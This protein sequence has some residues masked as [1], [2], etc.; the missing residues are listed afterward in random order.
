MNASMPTAE[1]LFVLSLGVV[2]CVG[3]PPKSAPAQAG[4]ASLAK[5]L[6]RADE[7]YR[8]DKLPD[9]AMLYRQALTTAAGADRHRCFDQLLA[10]YVRVG[11]QDQAIQTGKQYDAWLRK[12]GDGVRARALA[13]DLGRW[14]LAL[15]HYADAE[16][17]L[18]Q[19]LAD[20]KGAALPPA[21]QITALTYLALAAE[22]QGAAS[23]AAQAWR[24]VETFARTQLGD[25]GQQLTL[26]LRIECTRR[27]A[28]SYRFQG[29]PAEAIKWLEPVVS[30][31]GRLQKPDPAG[32]RD[33]LRQ[34]AAHLTAAKRHADA[35]KYLKEALEL[36]RKYA[37]DDPLTRADLS[38]ELADVLER[39]DRLPEATLLRQQ[40][41]QDYGSVLGDQRHPRPKLAGALAAFWK[42]Q[43]LHQRAGQ[44]NRALQLLQDSAGQWGGGLIEPRLHAEQGRLQVLLARYAPSRE[45]LDGVVVELE[46]QVPLN[47]IDLPP[48]L[49]NLAVAELATGGQRKATEATHRCLALYEKYRLADDLLLVDAYNLLGTCT[50]LDGNYAV[51]IG[52]FHEGVTRCAKLGD[53]A[54]PQRCSLWLNIALLH[55]AQGDP[56]AAQ[57][58]CEEA[59]KA[60]ER[61]AD[62]NTFGFAALD[63]ARAS[64]LVSQG[65]F[66][67]AKVLADRVL[68]VCQKHN[69]PE[70]TLMI[71]ARHCQAL[72]YLLRRDFSA[73]EEAWLKVAEL[74]GKQSPL[75]PR[76][77]NYLG[78]LR[79]CQSRWDEAAKFYEEAK[80]LQEKSPRAFP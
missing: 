62:T 68:A 51:A 65:K 30:D 63:A 59:Q 41:I 52:H 53:A 58:A 46:K 67:E 6:E 37:A 43:V 31:F 12:I 15:G 57:K 49:L 80:A 70:V 2:L 78:V 20:L 64:L 10:I 19:A 61:F 32:K 8:Q 73:A 72:F 40:A 69:R 75:R 25:A 76:T 45:L 34:L 23:R 22:K 11:R 74:Q 42:L 1:R 36:H 29:R 39:Q 66:D 77:L 50:A 47:L 3:V 44:Y 54:A 27:L 71:T 17:Y 5:T 48:A 16:P 28:D 55:K 24:E 38:C 26:P 4:G 7:L 14:H 79:E 18:R 21:K 9:A 33:T 35:E 13:L 56:K 60:Y